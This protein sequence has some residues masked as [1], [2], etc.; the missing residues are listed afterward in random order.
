MDDGAPE[1]PPGE[2]HSKEV[3]NTH[4]AG[5]LPEDSDLARVPAKC[6]DVLLYPFQRGDL[7]KQAQIRQAVAQ[8]EEALDTNPIAE[9]HAHHPIAGEPPAV[10]ERAPVA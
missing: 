1:Q 5:G 9:S 6:G 4:A 7:I 3:R 8:V 10:I 2:W